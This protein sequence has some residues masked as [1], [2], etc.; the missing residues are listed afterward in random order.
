MPSIAVVVLDSLRHDHFVDA[1]DWL[2]GRHFARAYA[3][4]HWTIPSHASLYTGRYPSEVGVHAK[5]PA[6]DVEDATLAERLAAAGYHT[7]LWT[8]QPQIFMWD[9]WTRGFAEAV[10]PATLDPR[11]DGTFDWTAFQAASDHTGARQY[12]SAVWACLRSERPTVPSLRN[13]VRLLRRSPA[14]GGAAALL[15]RLRTTTFGPDEF[16]F[17]NLMDAHIPYYPPTPGGDP[18]S[19]TSGHGFADAV[20]D[21]DHVRSAYAASVEVLASRYRAVYDELASSFDYVVTCAD[22]GELL[23]ERGLWNHG[24]GLLP[25]LIHVPLVVSGRDVDDETVE[26]TVGL[27][28][29]HRT[30]VELT[31]VAAPSR[32]QSL[33]GDPEPRPQLFEYHGFVPWM[34]EQFARFE[35]LPS[36]FFAARDPPRNGFV[37]PDGVYAYETHPDGLVVEGGSMADPAGHLAALRE[38]L[39]ARTV[40]G[41]SSGPTEGVRRQLEQLGYA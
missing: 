9:G 6:L 26:A 35:A 36:S 3:T 37:T 13:G 10:S 41:R 17:A 18:V 29:V 15:K 12:L 23:G 5:S 2:P 24:Y 25:E 40:R 30:V 16:L 39:D 32:G 22:H 34:R 31:G 38:P 27:L 4:S 21:P 20:T 19:V 8:A 33:L 7:R 1:F 11:A 14:D 28:D